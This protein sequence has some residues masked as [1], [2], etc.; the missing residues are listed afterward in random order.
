MNYS[1]QREQILKT[2]RENLVHPDA[3]NTFIQL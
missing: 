2:V 3:K 1:K